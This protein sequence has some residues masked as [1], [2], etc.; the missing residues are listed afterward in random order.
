LVRLLAELSSAEC[1]PGTRNMAL[2]RARVTG[3]RVGRVGFD[4]KR[5]L[6][7]KDRLDNQVMIVFIRYTRRKMETKI[8]V[9]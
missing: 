5:L 9:A 6:E 3:Y 1:L 4:L 2:K 7:D 8:P